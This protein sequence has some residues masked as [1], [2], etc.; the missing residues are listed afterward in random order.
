[1]GQHAGINAA[2]K[3]FQMG[4]HAGTMGQHAQE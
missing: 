4:Q 2:G 3:K 1:V